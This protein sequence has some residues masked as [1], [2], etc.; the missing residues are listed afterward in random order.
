MQSIRTIIP[1]IAAT[2]MFFP[3][4]T[5]K[6]NE[7]CNGSLV[8]QV[9]VNTE[10][11]AGSTINLTVSGIENVYMYNWYGPNRFS[12]HEQN[13]EIPNATAAIAGRYTVDVITKDGCIHT[14]VTDSVAVSAAEAPC[15]TPNNY[16]EFSNTFDV[17]FYSVSGSAGGGSYIVDANGSGGD[18]EMEFAG[19]RPV[20]GLYNITSYG[21]AW[22]QGYVRISITNGGVLWSPAG[23][24]VYVNTVNGKLVVSFCNIDFSGQGFKTK[25]NLK[26]TVP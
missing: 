12:S 11:L 24:K 19:S 14:A 8:P 26:V 10:V 13:P 2:L 22:A 20:T 17:S 16:A 18:L 25:V 3:A 21:G 4:C 9:T 23:G 6:D 7:S 15:T 5:S 1:A